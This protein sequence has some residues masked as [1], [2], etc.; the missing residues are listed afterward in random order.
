MLIDGNTTA[1]IFVATVTTDIRSKPLGNDATKK[2]CP[3]YAPN[4]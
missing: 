2:G 4:H 1:K 3:K